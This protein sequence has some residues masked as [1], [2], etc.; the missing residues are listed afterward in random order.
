MLLLFF[1][2]RIK[3]KRLVTGEAKKSNDNY[4]K[5]EHLIE[6]D[7]QTDIESTEIVFMST[8]RD[9]RELI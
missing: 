9:H 5:L 6:P 7:R 4:D 3:K 8:F 2:D 1:V